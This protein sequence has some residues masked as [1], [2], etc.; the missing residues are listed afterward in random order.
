MSSVTLTIFGNVMD[1]VEGRV[2]KESLRSS[3]NVHLQYA[4]GGATLSDENSFG[5][6]IIIDGKS[7]VSWGYKDQVR[8]EGKDSMLTP[9]IMGIDGRT[10]FGTLETVS[11]SS[12][13]KFYEKQCQKHPKGFVLLGR[14]LMKSF[15]STYIRKPPIFHENVID[16]FSSYWANP[17]QKAEA[18]IVL[19]AVVIPYAAE[20]IFSSDTLGHAFYKS[21]KDPKDLSFY[22]HTH[23][24]LVGETKTVESADLFLQSL[25]NLKVLGVRHTLLS[26]EIDHGQCL[27]FPIERIQVV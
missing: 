14:F 5:E 8:T 4:L 24:A 27:V 19:F 2:T 13:Q 6:G 3:K 21:P 26:S 10:P 7:W 15:S 12:L 23:S 11:S 25:K 22:S 17:E 16:R 20:K 9:F 1:V 18:S